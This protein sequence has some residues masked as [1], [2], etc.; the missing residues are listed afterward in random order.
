[1][2]RFDSLRPASSPVRVTPSISHRFP[3]APFPAHSIDALAPARLICY[4]HR[5]DRPSRSFPQLGSP[6][7][8]LISVRQR[9]NRKFAIAGGAIETRSLPTLTRCFPRS[10]TLI[11]RTAPCLRQLPSCVAVYPCDSRS[12]V[13]YVAHPIRSIRRLRKAHSA[14]RSKTDSFSQRLFVSERRAS[15][16]ECLTSPRQP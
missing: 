9:R 2:S 3:L 6:K 14:P 5:L 8:Q 13:F 7:S 16:P 1:M 10:F 12:H 15:K 4:P 11:T